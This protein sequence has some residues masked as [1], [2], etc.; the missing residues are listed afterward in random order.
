MNVDALYLMI[1]GSV[2]NTS[3]H[4]LH[5]DISLHVPLP[6]WD[7]SPSQIVNTSYLGEPHLTSVLLQWKIHGILT[8]LHPRV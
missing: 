3:P 6:E 8:Y 5:Y 1:L 7:T 4:Y 2:V